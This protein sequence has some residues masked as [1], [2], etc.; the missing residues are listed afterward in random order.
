MPIR[1]RMQDS[2]M[3]RWTWSVLAAMITTSLSSSLPHVSSVQ[4]Q[5]LDPCQQSAAAI[6]Q[7]TSLRQMALQGDAQA[8]SQYQI[9]LNQHAQQLQQC[10]RQSWLQTQAIWLRLHPCDVRPG[11]LDA[12]L[13]WMV[14]RGYNQVNVEVFANGQVLLPSSDNPTV[15]SSVV[16]APGAEQVD[17]LAQAIQ[18]GRERGLKVYAWMFTLN[19]GYTYAIRPDR[20]EVLAR[21][22]NGDTTL[23]AGT[24][25]SLTT[26]QDLTSRDEIFVD[27]Y[28]P[29][30]RS[31]YAQL[32]Q[33]VI[34]RRPDGVL[35]D[36]VRYPKGQGGASIASNVKD[37][38]IYGDAAQQA[39]LQRAQN[40]KGQ[41]LIRRFLAQGAITAN[42]L[43]D[44]DR[45]Y[46]N[47]SEPQWQGRT[48]TIA[49]SAS[50]TERQPKLQAELWN[51][52]IAHAMQGPIDFLSAVM[53]PIQQQGI[54]MG[55][56]F[57]PEGN[58]VV[59]QGFDSRLQAWEKFPSSLEWHPMAYA[60]CG[61]GSCIAAQVQR[62]L[63]RLPAGTQLQPVLA[64]IWQQTISNHPPLEVQMQ[65]MQAF[66]PKIN[67]VSHFAYS[68]QEPQ[69]DRDRKFCRLQ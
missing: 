6:A 17:L 54:S 12:L 63:E 3:Q 61:D 20:Q 5:S 50:A 25:A 52:T 43:L 62:V 15:W 60:I 4:A 35:F 24:K 57:F 18:K 1:L 58:Q 23:T 31:D 13:D 16:Q 51:L 48:P 59:K 32:V 8:Q 64:G 42:D 47:E 56:V 7:K 34:R 10:R 41:E 22:G 49:A 2:R 19:F 45:L 27:P 66:A 14:D 68:W 11:S 67:S 9:L 38:W 37:L 40:Q 28:N 55:A 29:Q 21:N 44:V 36:Y 69:A 26:G 39:L 53:A 46:A 33:A 65:A 30:A